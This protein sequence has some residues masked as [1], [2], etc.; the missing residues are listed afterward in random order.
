MN[1]ARHR[2]P[3]PGSRTDDAP[4][5]PSRARI[6]RWRAIAL[7]ALLLAA[8]DL[9]RT[10]GRQLSARALLAAIDLYQ[11]TL[12]PR[13]PAAGVSCRFEPSCSRYAEAVIRRDGALVGTL[14]SA[15]RI[16]RCGP[17]TPAG[18]VDPP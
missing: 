1:A 17:W 9:A 8:L 10:P 2:P 16:A 12:S 18:T 5:A 13:L 6:P 15:A 14:R 4:A 3:T 11:A 7:V